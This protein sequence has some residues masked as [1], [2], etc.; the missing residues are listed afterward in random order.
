MEFIEKLNML[1]KVIMKVTGKNKNQVD[2]IFRPSFYKENID[3]VLLAI[4]KS[5]YL[6][7]ELSDRKP[8]LNTYTVKAQID[9][10]LAGAFE[11]FEPVKTEKDTIDT[12]THKSKTAGE[13]LKEIGI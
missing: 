1:R 6:R 10:M 8:N 2:L 4:K 9:R 7:G 3:G 5:R 13:L 11:D 12:L